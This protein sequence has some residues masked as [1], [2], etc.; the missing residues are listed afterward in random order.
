AEYAVPG[1]ESQEIFHKPYVAVAPNGDIYASDPQMYRIYVYAADGAL[2]AAFGNYGADMTQIGLPT[3]LAIDATSN[4]I[5]VADADNNRV[6]VFPLL[7]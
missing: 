4:S 5:L 6:M 3:G 7:P 2:K 1:W